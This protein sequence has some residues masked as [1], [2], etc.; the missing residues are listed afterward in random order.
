MGLNTKVSQTAKSSLG[1][2]GV[3]LLQN[4]RL[5]GGAS[6]GFAKITLL[7]QPFGSIFLNLFSLRGWFGEEYYG[8][9]LRP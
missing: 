1:D 6:D 5:F 7:F 4:E 8:L 3:E 9:R 2:F